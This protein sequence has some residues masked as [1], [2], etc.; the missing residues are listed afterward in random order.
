LALSRVLAVE[1]EQQLLRS[2]KRL[3][4]SW[5][6]ECICVSTAK[7]GIERVQQEPRIHALIVDLELREG[8]LCGLSV[9][10]KAPPWVVPIVISGHSL[11]TVRAR[12]APKLNPLLQ[13]QAWFFFEKPLHETREKERLRA[14]IAASGRRDPAEP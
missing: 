13:G 7:E 5:G 10:E 11:H 2:Y 6:H 9:L 8:D 4:G 14:I 3:F 12:V 1:D